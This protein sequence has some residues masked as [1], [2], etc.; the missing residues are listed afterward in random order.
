VAV[1]NNGLEIFTLSPRGLDRPHFASE[2]RGLSGPVAVVCLRASQQRSTLI[3]GAFFI[4]PISS[5]CYYARR[6]H[7]T[8]VLMQNHRNDLSARAAFEVQ[9]RVD[10]LVEELVLGVGEDRDGGLPRELCFEITAL[11][12]DIEYAKTEPVFADVLAERGGVE[13]DFPKLR[14]SCWGLST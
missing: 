3:Y 6:P 8:S 12:R 7:I 14:L 9:L 5:V 10:N 1:T 2:G 11:E 13:R 4:K